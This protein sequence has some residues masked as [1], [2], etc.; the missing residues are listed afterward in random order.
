VGKRAVMEAASIM[1]IS[2]SYWSDNIGLIA[3]LTTLR[4]LKRRNAVTYLRAVGEQLRAAINHAIQDAGL[5]GSCSGIAANPYFSLT[6]P[7]GIDRR[8]VN[9]LFIQE[10]ARHGIHTL[11]SFKATLAH[12]DDE[13]AAT[14]RAATAACQ[15]IRRALDEGDLDRYLVADVTKEPFRR[16]VR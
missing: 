8:K 16:L 4:E 11:T 9:T 10:M 6:L 14:Q 5:Q 1:F 2:S 7:A 12:G 3:S 15:T 13:I